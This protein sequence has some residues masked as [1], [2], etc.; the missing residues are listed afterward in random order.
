MQDS[1]SMAEAKLA[2]Y[3]QQT[4]SESVAGTN[5]FLFDYQPFRQWYFAV[6]EAR[7]CHDVSNDTERMNTLL[8]W[9]FANLPTTPPPTSFYN[10]IVT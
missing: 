4:L 8:K 1:L 2:S 10:Q 5:K 3:I 9:T 7:Y 6:Q